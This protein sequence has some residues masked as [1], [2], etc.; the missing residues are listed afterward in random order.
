MSRS[1][2]AENANGISW[3]TEDHQWIKD[4]QKPV[5]RRMQHVRLHSEHSQEAQLYTA[6]AWESHV[7]IQI[8]GFYVQWL[9][10][11]RS[12]FYLLLLTFLFTY[13][14]MRSKTLKQDW[15]RLL[16][17]VRKRSPRAFLRTLFSG[18][19]EDR[20]PEY[21]GNRAI[22]YECTAHA[23]A[24]DRGHDAYA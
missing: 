4:G 17:A 20:T 18:R 8:L 6:L 22:G 19:N 9:F 13:I 14:R 10:R 5:C 3:A 15:T 21:V 2:A 23:L 12:L 11:Y 1:N 7:R 16:A 24:F